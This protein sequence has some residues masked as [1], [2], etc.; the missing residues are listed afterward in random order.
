MIPVNPASAIVPT[1]STIIGGRRGFAGSAAPGP[2][3]LAAFPDS[4]WEPI[5][6]P[7]AGG[8]TVGVSVGCAVGVATA[9]GDASA[10]GAAAE[11]DAGRVP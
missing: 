11:S 5:D 6:G 8:A 1:P 9:V 2:E 3:S 10:V 7:A 4:A